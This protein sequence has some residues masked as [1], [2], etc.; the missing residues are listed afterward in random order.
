MCLLTLLIE[1]DAEG[2]PLHWPKLPPSAKVELIVLVLEESPSLPRRQPPFRA[3]RRERRQAD[4]RQIGVVPRPALIY[5]LFAIPSSNWSYVMENIELSEMLSQ[6]RR[7][8]S[9]AQREGAGSDLKF[10]I[11]DI[12]IELQVATTS[13]VAGKT[14]IK[15][16]V[17]W[18]AE[19]SAGID[20]TN[21][22][23]LKLKLK[24]V[25]AGDGSS[26]K[27]GGAGER[28]D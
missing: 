2:N 25:N 22:Q 27:A 4:T 3:A 18:D 12:E 6:L 24:P 11:E 5:W 23:K 14:G 9:I 8:L 7:E 1:T 16:L 17:C 26:F 10:Q 21:T 15:I 13:K 28:G 20:K 19:A